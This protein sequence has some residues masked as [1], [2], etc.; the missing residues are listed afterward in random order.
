MYKIVYLAQLNTW[1]SGLFDKAWN[2]FLISFFIDEWM[3]LAV[4][5]Q[6][7]KCQTMF[8]KVLFIEL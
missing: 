5:G 1:N 4:K 2:I 3:D 7:H 8:T 6:T